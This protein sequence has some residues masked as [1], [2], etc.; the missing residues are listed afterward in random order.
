MTSVHVGQRQS[1]TSKASVLSLQAHLSVC[2]GKRF[3]SLLQPLHAY[4]ES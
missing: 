2:R 1:A 4:E 3:C